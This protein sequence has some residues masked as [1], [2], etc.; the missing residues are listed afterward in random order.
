MSRGLRILGWVVLGVVALVAIL[1]IFGYGY[2]RTGL[3]QTDGVITIADPALGRQVE[4]RRDR[5]GVPHILAQSLDDA[6][7]ALGFVHAQDRLWQMEMN[8]RIAAGRLAEVLG[9]QAVQTDVY[10]R[11]LSL[12][13]AAREAWAHLDEDTRRMLKSYAA[14]VNAYIDRHHGAWPPEFLL[15][16]LRPE[17]WT[18]IDSLGWLKVMALDLGGNFRRELARLDL[19]SVLSPEQVMQFYPPYPGEQP[20]PLPDIAALYDGL[21]IADLGI[22]PGASAAEKGLGSNN[23]VVAGSR[24]ASGKPL[25]ANDPHLR[26]NTPSL[27]YLAAIK[28]GEREVVGA[29][30][31][32]VPFIVL[33]RTDRIAWGFTNTGPDVQDLYLER[34]ADDG[35][36]VETPDGPERLRFRREVIRVKDGQPVEIRVRISRHGPLISDAMP[37]L[38]ARLPKNVALALRWTALDPDDTS[39]AIGLGF[40]RA[41]DFASFQAALHRFVVPEQNMV[42]ADREGHIGYYAPARVP[43]RSPANDTHGLIPAPGWKPG[44]DWQGFI[45]YD[46]LPTRFDPPEGFIATANE[47]VVGPDYP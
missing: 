9:P 10:L 25:L 32:G 7:F 38:Q 11:T 39:A 42:Y 23:W 12:F 45:P 33:G 36:N 19:L 3:P 14:G 4:I 34:I 37:E 30:M 29:S 13:D 5:H 18:P 44:Y 1:A 31:P 41:H 43:I 2:L 47:K 28:V 8:R 27:W 21:K 17:P 46:A 15:T 22:T 24:T 26:L 16:D 20:L 6:A 35:L 40:W